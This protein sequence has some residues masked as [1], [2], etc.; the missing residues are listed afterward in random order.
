[1]KVVGA[2]ALLFGAL[3]TYLAIARHDAFQSNAFDLGYVTQTLW[4]TDH[5]QPYRFTTVTGLP[6]SPEGNLDPARL[7]QPPSLL[8]FHV[9]PLLLVIAPLFALWPDPVFLLILQALVLAAGALAAG[10][11]ALARLCP[12]SP[13]PP[14]PQGGRGSSGSP[15]PLVGEGAGGRGSGLG[16]QLIPAVFGIAYLLSPSVAA[17]ALSDF[18]AVALGAV[19]L[20]GSLAAFAANRRQLAVVLAVLAAAGRE[21]AA[22]AVAL[23]GAYLWIRGGRPLSPLPP[24]PPGGRRSLNSSSPLV[25]EGV[26]GKGG[27]P[28]TTYG[29]TGLALMLGAGL[30][31]LLIFGLITPFFNGTISALLHGQHAVGSIFWHRYSWLGSSPPRAMVN[32]VIHPQLWISWLSQRDVLAYLGTLV[33]TGGGVALLAPGALALSL[34]LVLENALSSFEWMRSGGA[35]YSIVG[36]PLLV[37]AGVEGARRVGRL[38]L[39]LPIVLALALVNHVWLAASP[40]VPGLI[41]PTPDA[42]DRAL[43]AELTRLPP[44][45]SV[46]ASSAVYPHLATRAAAFW[47]PAVNVADYVALDL[48]RSTDPV[49]PREV[50]DRVDAL[51]GAGDYGVAWAEPG[52][53]ILRRGAPPGEVPPI[54]GTFARAAPNAVGQARHGPGLTFGEEVH[55]VGYR[56]DRAPTI[57]VFGPSATLTTYWQTDHRLA[58]QLS[59]VFYLT[60]RSDGAIV[61]DIRDGAAEAVWYPTPR[62]QPGETVQ[63]RINL[64]RLATV[65]AVGVA[66]ENPEGERL[67]ITAEPGAALW[68][69]RTIGRV[70]W[71]E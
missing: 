54:V 8:A 32:A 49:G 71:V 60:R 52:L 38:R 44:F 61:G 68:E 53:L 46:S 35:H 40:L 33:L 65:Q 12:L 67:P 29:R 55:L 50:K 43:A 45:S 62:W 21:D 69:N 10:W 37:F 9:E 41:W 2:A 6:F 56:L 51:L 58:N 59:F 1:M 14:P 7:H 23:V 3:W 13:Q 18:H 31:V 64:P 4:Y 63:L 28:L 47:F 11:L 26:G 39:A 57:T 27:D 20:L 5:G 25:G 48:Q 22:I 70:V 42:S 19:A 30:W 17:A 24:P 15:S 66:V 36:I 34:P 16:K